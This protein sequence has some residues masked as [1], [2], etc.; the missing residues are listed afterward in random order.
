MSYLGRPRLIFA[1][2]FQ[3]DPSTVNNDPEHF[4]TATFKPGYQ[5]PGPDGGWWNPGGHGIWG[6]R[7]CTIRAVVYRDG[8]TCDDPNLDPIVG[9]PINPN[10][11]AVPAKLV[12]LDP[13]QQG[14]TELWGFDVAAGSG[15]GPGFSGDFAVAAFAD[16]WPRVAGGG[17]GDSV[18]A[19]AY[20]SV[21]RAVRWSG[22][23]D[24]RFLQELA[25]GGAPTELSIKFNLDGFNDRS[26]TTGF[27]LGRVVGSIGPYSAG[28]PR[29]F[30]AGRVLT[31][32]GN[33]S[34]GTAYAR[35]DG[36]V[37]ALDLGNSLPTRSSGGPLA[38]T[39]PLALALIP[40]G[41]PAIPIGQIPYTTPGWYQRTAGIVS[42]TL[43]PDQL[44]Q[45]AGTPL[46]LV[47]PAGNAPQAFLAEAAD[48]AWVRADS[49]VFRL[50]PGDEAQTTFYATAF[51]RRIAGA[52]I[53]LGYDASIMQGQTTQGPIPGP[54]VVGQPQSALTFPT[55]I[56]TGPDGTA[57]LTL[58]AGDP[59][60]PRQY[61][62]GQVYGVGYALGDAP[63]PVGSITNSSL[64]L[65]ALVWSGYHAPAVPDWESDVGP[66]L[67]QYA[68]LYP[69]MK[70]IVDLSSYDGVVAK[71]ALIKGVFSV[72]MTDPRYMPITR[73]LSRAKREMILRWLDNP[74]RARTSPR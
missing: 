57:V 13:E 46:G 23:G 56:R 62:D 66:I 34:F 30:V 45:A 5:R 53:S 17:Q 7:G 25:A 24:S 28:E 64:I 43:T 9:A 74:I 4:D 54:Q 18:L 27:T 68:D 36:D 12:D 35:I 70:P 37:L 11:P 32:T 22:A 26:D 29:C 21:L 3:A 40:P 2:Q 10:A 67:L 72:P 58:K 44:T 38:D 19:A 63:P 59:G 50:N 31:S 52:K 65:S 49:Y 39:G 8:S 1:G 73:D 20:Q 14:V 71:R 6:F 51:G 69:V 16:L 48:G 42:F 15:D 55:S 41:A 47:P 33:P 60:R 61:I